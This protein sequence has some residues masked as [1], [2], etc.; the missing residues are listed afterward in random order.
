M[1]FD[2]VPGLLA[3]AGQ[4]GRE[5]AALELD[6]GPTATAD[7]MVAVTVVGCG[8]AVAAVVGMDASYKAELGQQVQRAIHRYQPDGGIVPLGSLADF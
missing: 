2:R 3:D 5:V 6:G 8:I 7:Q 4:E 1:I